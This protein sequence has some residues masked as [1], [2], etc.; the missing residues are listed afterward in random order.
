MINFDESPFPQ[1]VLD[2][3]QKIGFTEP[4]PIQAQGWPMA[5]SGRDNPYAELYHDLVRRCTAVLDAYP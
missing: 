1:Y 5:L 2:E 4:T 3:I